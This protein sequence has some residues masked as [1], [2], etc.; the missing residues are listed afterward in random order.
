[1]S[2]VNGWP[3][4]VLMLLEEI[5]FANVTRS[6]LHSKKIPGSDIETSSGG[7]TNNIRAFICNLLAALVADDGSMSVA[8]KM[9][10]QKKNCPT[11]GQ[12]VVGQ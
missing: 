11:F 2:K 10:D 3:L 1:M 5:F 12:N 9:G 8:S 6:T 7:R 4:D